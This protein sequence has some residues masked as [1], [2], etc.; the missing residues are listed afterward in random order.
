M[1]GGFCGDSSSKK[2]KHDD[3]FSVPL[4]MLEC[5]VC[6]ETMRDK[7]FQCPS[8]HS[9]CGSCLPNLR[10]RVCPTC[11]D[12]FPREPARNFALEQILAIVEHKCKNKSCIF[13]STSGKLE[14]HEKICVW[15]PFKCPIPSCNWES[16]GEGVG[17]MHQASELVDHLT[18]GDSKHNIYMKFQSCKDA[19]LGDGKSANM[20][21]PVL[22][23]RQPPKSGCVTWLIKFDGRDFVVTASLDLGCIKFAG[24]CIGPDSSSEQYDKAV[25]LNWKREPGQI[26][27][28]PEY[29]ISIEIE[30]K[31]NPNYGI[32]Y[33]GGLYYTREKNMNDLFSEGRYFKLDWNQMILMCSVEDDPDGDHGSQDEDDATKHLLIGTISIFRK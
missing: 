30:D 7:V 12:K 31:R 25:V 8:G 5:P 20:R 6:F 1:S 16:R 4:K 11:R 26:M 2:R 21:I 10:D 19:V 33:Q 9:I 27:N 15:N 14:V 22:R 23:S 28:P 29:M 3:L 17:G 32:K 24:L 18:N 13:E